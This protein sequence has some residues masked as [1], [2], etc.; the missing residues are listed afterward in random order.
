MRRQTAV[1]TRRPGLVSWARSASLSVALITASHCASTQVIGANTVAPP[2]P[3]RRP[4]SRRPLI[5]AEVSRL[6]R[7][8]PRGRPSRSRRLE[9]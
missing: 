1:L 8:G 2:R 3:W 9:R 4:C 6:R 5:R 7:T